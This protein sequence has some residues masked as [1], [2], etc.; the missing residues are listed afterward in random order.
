M[1]FRAR[2]IGQFPT[3]C[4]SATMDWHSFFFWSFP[5]TRFAGTGIRISWWVP[6]FAVL[7]CILM[8]WQLGL[9]LTVIVMFCVLFHEFGHV[10]AA[11]A[12]GGAADEIIV[13]PLG[14]L[15]LA[16]PGPGNLAQFLTAGA[17][18]L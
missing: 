6:V 12:T 11:R 4:W 17:G 7:W 18:P 1:S 14:G 13:S 10:L 2:R 15:A 16:Q 8:G 3:A 5:V 9:A